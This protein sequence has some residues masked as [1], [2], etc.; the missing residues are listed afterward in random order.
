MPLQIEAGKCYRSRV[1]QRVQVPAPRQGVNVKDYPFDG[2]NGES[3][4]LAGTVY[5][6]SSCGDD[7]IEEY[8]EAPKT[9]ESAATL[10]DSGDRT[11][12]A[13]GAVRDAA[14]GKGL[15]S[16]IP[17]E[18]IR[19]LGRH[20]EAGANKYGRDNWMRG[21]PLTRYH[22]AIIR[23]TLAAAEGRT[24]EDH[25]A[26]V[27]WNAAAWLWTEDAIKRGELPSDL[28]DRTYTEKAANG[29]RAAP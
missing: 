15:P 22:D 5:L 11:S 1:G 2:D 19:R 27:M 24:E 3:Y 4:T 14:A 10:P 8:T 7:L 17:P 23:H 25:L 16:L 28:D 21:I 13:T 20:F 9:R 6:E 29:D 18:A 26:A 12:F